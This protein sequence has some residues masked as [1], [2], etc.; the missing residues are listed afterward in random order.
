MIA[1][2]GFNMG[3]QCRGYQFV[4]GL[5]VTDKANC[6]EN[7]FHCAENPLDCLI[8]YSDLYRSEYYIVNASGDIDEDGNDSKIACTEIRV[9]KKMSLQD[10]LL[11]GLAY[12]VDHPLR[13]WNC[14]VKK[15]VARAERGYAVVRGK[16]P[17]ALG[18][19]G[20]ILAFAK[21]D[22]ETEMIIQLAITQVDGKKI[23]SDTWYDV[24]L[25][26]GKV[27]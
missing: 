13:R 23:R 14:Y 19:K 20:D 26:E 24:D 10:L 7:G 8:Y 2:K 1:Y 21:E 6:R 22:P 4:M 16:N 17:V 18:K 15:D 5:N 9:I 27:A 11:H 12:M 25:R 3:L